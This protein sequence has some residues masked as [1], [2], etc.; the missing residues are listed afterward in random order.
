M[1]SENREMGGTPQRVSDS[2]AVAGELSEL[3]AVL[4]VP[5]L[6]LSGV[7]FFFG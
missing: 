7:S 2:R 1:F 5:A 6:L 3:L 4:V